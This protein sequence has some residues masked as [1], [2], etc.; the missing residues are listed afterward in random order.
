MS[1]YEDLKKNDVVSW[2]LPLIKS[3]TY[4]VR[5]SDGRFKL[6]P[7]QEPYESP[8]H[9]IGYAEG[10]NCPYLHQH[11]FDVISPRTPAGKFIPRKCQNCYKIVIRPKNL[12]QLF[13]LENLLEQIKWP[14]K[15]GIEKRSYTPLSKHRYGGYI[16]NKGMQEGLERLQIIRKHIADHPVLGPDV[17][18]YLKRS[19]TEMEMAFPDSSKWTVTDEQNRVEDLLDWLIIADIPASM[20]SKHVLDRIHMGWVEWAA[21]NGDETYLEYTDGRPLFQQCVKY[22]PRVEGTDEDTPQDKT[23]GVGPSSRA[24]PKGNTRKPTKGKGK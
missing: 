15:C 4:Q 22:E 13:A 19:C 6:Q 3:G 24:V 8:W 17:E 5:R 1:Y 16:Y 7:V 2:I 12:R 11:L 21:E 10:G 9:H 23:V 18:S 14:S 20:T